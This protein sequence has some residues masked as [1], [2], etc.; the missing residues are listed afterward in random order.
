[1][2]SRPD[3]RVGVSAL[4]LVRRGTTWQIAVEQQPR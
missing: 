3:I 2:A 4:R 1:L